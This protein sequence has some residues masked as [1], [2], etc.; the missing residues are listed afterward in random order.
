MPKPRVAI[1]D[2]DL[3]NAFATGR[4]PSRAVVCVT[5][6]ILRPLDRRGARGRARPRALPRR[7]PRRA[8]D[9]G[10]PSSAGIVAGH[11]DARRAVRR[12]GLRPRRQQRRRRRRLLVLVVSLV[13]YAI[14]FLLLRLLSR[15]RE[16]SRRPLRRLPD[17]AAVGAGLGADK[18]SGE[19]DAV[20]ERDLRAAQPMNAFFIAPAVRGLTMGTLTATHPPLEQRL[21]QLAKIATEPRPAVLTRGGLL[22]RPARADAPAAGQARR[23]VLA[24]VGGDDARGLAG[25][26]RRPAS[27][28]CASG[29]P[30][31][32]PRR[33]RSRRPSDAD[34]LR[35]GPDDES[36][37]RRV[38]LHLAHRAHRP[39]RHGA[40]VTDLHA[41][42]SAW[43]P[44]ASARRCCARWSRSPTRG[45]SA[46]VRRLPLQ[47]RHLLPLLRRPG[48][49]SRDT[50]R[51]ASCATRVG[52]DLPSR[53]TT[54]APAGCRSVGG[55]PR[56]PTVARQSRWERRPGRSSIRCSATCAQCAVSGRPRSTL[57]TL[58]GGQRLQRPD[59]VRQVDPV[60]RRAVADG[61][62]EEAI[63]CPGARRRG[64]GPGSARCRSP[65]PSRPEPPRGSDDVLGRADVVGGRRPRGG[66]PGA[67]ARSRPGCARAR[68][69]TTSAVKRPCTEQW[70]FHRIIRHRAAAS[71]SGRRSGRCGFQTTQSSSEMPSSQHRGVAAQVLV[72]QE[73]H[74]LSGPAARRPTPAR[75]AALEE[76]QT[77]PPWRPQNALMSAEEFM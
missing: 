33:P 66:T 34:R 49:A 13:V 35:R 29:P 20:P 22:G 67:R 40:L 43:R 10:R 38:R 39:A 73:Q 31:A 15:Y 19:M 76:V 1:A 2:T 47:A 64:A 53:R 68:S 44:R 51:S 17:P 72:G 42:N 63:S 46:G 6:G 50:L 8:G 3:P 45:P 14:S 60:H 41:V 23:A 16:L 70:P 11:G 54:G 56:A 71:A 74:L 26:A 28:R 55:A 37:R 62:V 27:A 32:R 18:I 5:T 75:P 21:D 30:R 9:D 36:R 25:A 7:P 48:P 65:R 57:T 59:E 24:A 61:L 52:A 12:A 77:A 4:S 69:S 58:A